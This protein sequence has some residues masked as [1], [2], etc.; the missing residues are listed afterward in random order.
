VK[1]ST[2]RRAL[3]LLALALGGAVA[4]VVWWLP[5]PSGSATS[6]A[7]R[8]LE[9][10]GVDRCERCHEDETALWRGSHHD[11]AMAEATEETVLGDFA[12]TSFTYAGVTSRFYRRGEGF[13]VET[14]GPDGA[15]T[16]FPI[17]YVFG[18]TPLQQYLAPMPDGRYQALGIAWDSRPAEDGGQRWFHLYPGENVDYRDVLHWTKLSQSWDSQCAECHSTNLRK[19]YVPPEDR[20]ATTFSEIDVSCEACHGPGS[21]H[22]A[23]AEEAERRETEPQ[24]DPGLVVRFDERRHRSWK[25]DMERGIAIPKEAPELR[26]ENEMCGRCHARRGLLTEDYLPG[27]L[28][29]QTHHPALLEEGLYY[30]DGQMEDEV[31]NWG[32]FL[33]SKM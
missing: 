26:V 17:D 25:M 21:R 12:D 5:G 30:P 2:R 27:Q 9:W 6:T 14:D 20:F 8:P 10:V 13:F 15:L 7:P 16:E 23:W 4:A 29:A 1:P 33:Q 24:G 11:R 31:Y 3:A 22:V 18:F 32:S 28:L 19:H